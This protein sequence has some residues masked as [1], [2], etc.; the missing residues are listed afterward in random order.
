MTKIEQFFSRYE[1]GANSFDPDLVTSQFTPCFAGGD[2]NGVVCIQNDE[3]FRKAIP[4]RRVFFQQIGFKSAKVLSIVETPLTDQYT[5]AK[6]RWH[7]VFE[8][9]SGAPRG[10]RFFITYFLFDPGSGPKVAFYMMMS[11][12]SCGKRG[13]FRPM[14]DNRF[15]PR[16]PAV[17]F[18]VST[19][20]VRAAHAG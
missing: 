18:R 9:E 5:M 12:R 4:E 6:V 10:F 13:S 7:L 19:L 3:A 1:E 11:K 20:A 14:P 15:N 17:G 2:P 16:C 8:K